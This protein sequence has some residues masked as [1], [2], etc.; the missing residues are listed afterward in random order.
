MLVIELKPAS[1]LCDPRVPLKLKC[2]FYKTVIRS[3]MLYVVECWPT[4]RRYCKDRWPK[5][6]AGELGFFCSQNFNAKFKQS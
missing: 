1:V 6:G 3:A 5:R 2:K 4:K